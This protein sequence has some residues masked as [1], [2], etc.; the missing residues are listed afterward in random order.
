[1]ATKMILIHAIRLHNYGNGVVG[2]ELPATELTPETRAMIND[3]FPK[4]SEQVY[5]LLD[6]ESL[7]DALHTGPL[8]PN[9]KNR[10][11]VIE[12]DL[13]RKSPPEDHVTPPK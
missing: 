6:Q 11:D 10:H 2:V 7:L 4:L 13:M 8:P 9:P 1:M 5:N 3:L 12:C